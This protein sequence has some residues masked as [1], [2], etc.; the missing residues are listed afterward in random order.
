MIFV[1]TQK[2]IFRF[3]FP[4][5]RG[6]LIFQIQC[7]ISSQLLSMEISLQPSQ[8]RK[9]YKKRILEKLPP[10]ESSFFIDQF[11]SF[12]HNDDYD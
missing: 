8:K 11:R 4:I 5:E 9:L 12:N 6:N 10:I 2:Q 3:N 1:K 7:Q